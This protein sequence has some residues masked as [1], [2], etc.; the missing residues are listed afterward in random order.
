M[1]K[2]LSL[3]VQRAFGE[4]Y[5]TPITGTCYEAGIDPFFNK[6]KKLFFFLILIFTGLMQ[7]SLASMGVSPLR[8]RAGR[9]DLGAECAAVRWW[10]PAGRWG[11]SITRVQI[12]CKIFLLHD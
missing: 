1:I 11:S 6:K 7:S 8:Q 10:E 5:I 2:S 9:A 4:G 12:A 3:K